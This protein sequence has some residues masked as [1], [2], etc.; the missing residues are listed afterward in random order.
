MDASL[1]ADAPGTVGSHCG[2]SIRRPGWP[3]A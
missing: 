3:A 1:E 2:S